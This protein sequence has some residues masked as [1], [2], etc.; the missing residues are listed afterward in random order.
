MA[1]YLFRKQGALRGRVRLLRAPR[2][3]G[4]PERFQRP[5]LTGCV[6]KAIGFDS[7]TFRRRLLHAVLRLN[8][9]LVRPAFLALVDRARVLTETTVRSQRLGVVC[10]RRGDEREAY[11]LTAQMK[12]VPSSGNEIGRPPRVT[13][14]LPL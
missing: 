1:P 13:V 8:V 10:G 2:L 9:L 6:A 11:G 14:S 5:L 7:H 4:E 3:E 12:R